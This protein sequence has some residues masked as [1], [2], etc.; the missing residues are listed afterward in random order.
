MSDSGDGKG[1]LGCFGVVSSD[2][3]R[4]YH[5]Y[6][7][8]VGELVALVTRDMHPLSNEIVKDV[9]TKSGIRAKNRNV[10]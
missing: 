6:R 7:A 4:Y 9:F 10:S 2:N 5:P 1:T 3:P 8:H